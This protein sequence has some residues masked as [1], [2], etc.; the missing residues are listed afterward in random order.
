MAN[1]FAAVS[2]IKPTKLDTI[3]E[4]D[5]QGHESTDNKGKILNIKISGRHGGIA[6]MNSWYESDTTMGL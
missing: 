4:E 6:D 1:W 5:E 2:I 3:L